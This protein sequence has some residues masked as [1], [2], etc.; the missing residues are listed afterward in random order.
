MN[1]VRPRA[2]NRARAPVTAAEW[3]FSVPVF[4][5]TLVLSTVDCSVFAWFCWLSWLNWSVL[6]VVVA[7][8][9]A[10]PILTISSVGVIV[11]VEERMLLEIICPLSSKTS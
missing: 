4:G 5:N 2:A 9:A 7:V 11:T 10:V 3:L 1:S 8:V 6:F